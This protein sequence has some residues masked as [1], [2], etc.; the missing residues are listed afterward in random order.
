MASAT[1]TATNPTVSK[2]A[3]TID[4]MMFILL[5]PYVLILRI[6]AYAILHTRTPIT[7]QEWHHACHARGQLYPSGMLSNS[8][9]ISA[10]IMVSFLETQPTAAS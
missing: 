2:T 6:I 10:G 3:I 8:A 5:F 1:M 9:R 7:S 4:L